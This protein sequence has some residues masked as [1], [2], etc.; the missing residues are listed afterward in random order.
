L[1]HDIDW[2]LFV[3]SRMISIPPGFCRFSVYF[4]FEFWILLG[5]NGESSCRGRISTR[6]GPDGIW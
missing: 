6:S 2:W 5:L 3:Y 1:Q 4:F